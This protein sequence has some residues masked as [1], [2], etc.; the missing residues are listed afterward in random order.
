MAVT[1]VRPKYDLK[2]FS[3]AAYLDEA[4]D[5]P[6]QA[7]ILLQELGIHY[8]VLRSAW[9]TNICE[10]QDRAC[11]Q[12]RD[13]LH[14][15]NITPVAI[16]SDLG[17][18][19]VGLLHTITSDKIDRAFNLATYFKA[20]YVRFQLGTKGKPG[21]TPSLT[22]WMDEITSKS[23]SA[24]VTPVWEPTNESHVIQASDIAVLMSKNRRWK[25]LYDPVQFIIR[26]NLDPFKKYWSLI[27]SSVIAIDVR[28]YKIGYGFK[29]VGFGDAKVQ[30]TLSDAKSSNFLGWLFIEPSLGRKHGSALTKQETFKSAL[31][32][33]CVLVEN[34]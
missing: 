34:I 29:P 11:T 31:N 25:L 5:D 27:K 21:P 12:L 24:N 14:K 17:S 19:D 8:A 33:V 16:L 30:H 2:G 3:V 32:A 1:P 20:Q 18:I 10:L 23:L 4:A 9:A 6:E 15:Y 28:D 7:C 26:Q 22:K 13:L